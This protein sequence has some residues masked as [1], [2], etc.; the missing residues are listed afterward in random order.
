M[1]RTLALVL[2]LCAASPALAQFDITTKTGSWAG[3]GQVSRAGA[4]D[5]VTCRVTIA[6]DGAATRVEGRCAVPE[7]AVPFDVRL[8]PQGDGSV[9]ATGR[10]LE[11]P[12]QTAITE[13]SGTPDAN[14]LTLRGTA[15]GETLTVQFV[16]RP[17]GGLRIATRRIT[18]EGEENTSVVELMPR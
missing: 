6:E 11:R 16:P 3:T 7:G 10:T 9:R 2:G 13:L 14:A 8:T 12:G 15:P 18:P 17:E 1:V 4:L 5:Q